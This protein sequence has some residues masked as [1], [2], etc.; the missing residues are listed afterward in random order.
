V[1]VEHHDALFLDRLLSLVRKPA[2]GS[3]TTLCRYGSA[4]ESFFPGYFLAR[5]CRTLSQLHRRRRQGAAPL[6]ISWRYAVSSH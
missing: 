2:K 5:S 3:T 6:K 1:A 4:N